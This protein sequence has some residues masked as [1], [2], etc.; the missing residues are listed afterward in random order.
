MG[1]VN[2]QVS[3]TNPVINGVAVTA[4]GT[5]LNLA[6]L[7]APVDRLLG[8]LGTQANWNTAPDNLA[9]C[10]DGDWS[11]VT[12][13]AV[14]NAIAAYNNSDG[15]IMFDM[16]ATYNV[17]VRGLVKIGG[18]EGQEYGLVV[19]DATTSSQE[20]SGAVVSKWV[21]AGT[22][23][24]YFDCFLR[25]RYVKLFARNHG[26]TQSNIYLAVYEIQALDFGF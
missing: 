2:G 7:H 9:Y 5:A 12:G 11:T 26:G 10:T 16:G 24:M 13:T 23:N 6:G 14:D 8:I 3:Q 25:G 17:L 4:T 15:Y 18:V 22:V 21:A 20:I 19:T 1:Q